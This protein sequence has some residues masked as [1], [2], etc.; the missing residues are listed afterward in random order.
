MAKGCWLLKL[1][2]YFRL[3]KISVIH[4]RLN[5][6]MFVV[7][8]AEIITL[9]RRGVV[10]ANFGVLKVYNKTIYFSNEWKIG[11]KHCL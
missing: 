4:T 7:K 9:S 2:G 6:A 10:L 8:L 1:A 3:F 11:L 5:M